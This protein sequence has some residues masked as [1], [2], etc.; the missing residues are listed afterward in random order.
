MNSRK[1]QDNG[2]K[3]QFVYRF[4]R[5]KIIEFM[6]ASAEEKLNWLEEANDF[7]NTF[8]SSEKMELWKKI[9]D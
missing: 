9:K 7:V 3:P 4:S 8:V 5:E 6:G 1:K 2:N